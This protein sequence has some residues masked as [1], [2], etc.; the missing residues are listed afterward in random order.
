VRERQRERGE[1]VEADRG[2]VSGVGL[3]LVRPPE[4][5]DFSTFQST[6]GRDLL[7]PFLQ[8]VFTRNFMVRRG[9]SAMQRKERKGGGHAWCH[10]SLHG[11][12]RGLNLCRIE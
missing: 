5:F 8:S 12:V 1:Y 6:K 11:L 3:A 9:R 2:G 4:K 7:R 10:I